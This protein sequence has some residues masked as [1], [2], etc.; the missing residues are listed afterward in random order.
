MST[1][2]T[3]Q[4]IQDKIISLPNRP[5]AM[6]DK[7]LAEL[8]EVETGNLNK[9]VTRNINRFPEDFRFQVT[10]IEREKYLFQIGISK[11]VPVNPYLFTREGANMLSAVL[12]SDIAVKRSVQIMRAFSKMEGKVE[13]ELSR[14][15]ILKLALESEEGRLKERAEKQLALKEKDCAFNA[16]DEALRTKAQ[17]NNKKTATAMVTASNLKRENNKLKIKVDESESWKT[18]KSIS[19]LKDYFSLTKGAYIAI[20][21]RLTKLSN[22]KGFKIKKIPS[23]DYGT[24]NTYHIQVINSFKKLINSDICIMSRYRKA[25][26]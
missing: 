25:V 18:V 14:L 8:Y 6:L 9:A 17:I 12:R 1:E 5:E 19:W 15:D 10:D 24:V 16:R 4:T 20:A 22:N 11:N 21:K 23:P 2:I 3:I 26:N 7:D 13:T